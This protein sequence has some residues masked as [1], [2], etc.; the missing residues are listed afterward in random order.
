M[1]TAAA[2]LRLALDDPQAAADALAPVLNG[3]VCRADQARMV[4]VL[5]YLPTNLTVPEIASE[6]Y[7]SRNTV[8]THLRNLCAKLGA[9][10]RAQAVA[11]VF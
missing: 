2:A 6:L 3:S 11:P 8:N 7:L 4:T 1:R 5:R 9:H 10:R